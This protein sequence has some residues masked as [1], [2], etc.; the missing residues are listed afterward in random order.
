LPQLYGVMEIHNRKNVLI[1]APT[2]SGKTLTCFLSILNEL[3]DSSLKGILEDKVYA[4]YVSP[5]KALNQDIKVNLTQPLE[6]LEQLSEKKLGIRVGVRTGDTTAY[7]K[8]KMLKDPPHILITTPESLAIMLNS[9]KFL[10]H[11]SSVQWLIVDEIHSLAENK[12]GVHLSLS[13]ERLQKMCPGVTRVGLS[14]TIAPLEDIAH[15]LVGYNG[16]EER[17]CGIVDVQFLKEMDLKVVSPVRSLVDTD[18]LLKH[19]KM[20]DTM[21]E[22][23]Q[24][25]KTTLIFTNTRSA[26]ERVVHN[27]KEMY[28]QYYNGENIAAHHGSLG[29]TNRF[30]TEQNLRDGKLKVV[31]SSTSLELGIDIGYID[32]VICL[33]SPKSVARLLQRAGRAGHQLH[34]IVK[35]RVIVMDRDDLVECALLLKS[36]VEKKIDRVH[37]PKNALDVLAQHIYGIAINQTINIY[38]LFH[39]IKNTFCYHTLE[40]SD[41]F[42]TIKYL[43]GEYV[44][45]EERHVYAR[46]WHDPETGMI[47]RRG[48]MARIIYMTNIGTIPEETYVTVKIGEQIVGKIDEGFLERLRPGDVFVLGG[49]VYMF[50]FSRGMTAQVSTSVS[51]PPT[52]PSWFSEMLPL[53]FDLA[54]E[55]GRFRRLMEDRFAN[56]KSKEE[57]LQFIH[58]YLYVDENAA[59]SIYHYFYEQFHFSVI[60]SD[61]KIVIETYTDRGRTYVLFNTLFGRRVNDC[62]SRSLAYVIG[63]SQHRDVEIGITDNGFYLSAE[64]TFNAIRAFELLKTENFR[65]VLEQAIE[66]SEVLQRRFRHCA[67]RSLMILRDYMGRKKNVG[68]MHI[69]SKILFNAVKRISNDFPILKEARREVLEDLMDYGH[70]QEIIDAVVDGRIVLKEVQ[71]GM[72]GP[73][74]FGLIVSGYNDV[75]KIEDKHEFL[76]RMHQTVLANI[77]LKQGKKK[78]QEKKEEFSYAKLWQ[79]A[80]LKQQEEK[81]LQKEKMKM[82]VWNLKH[83][84]IYAK[85]ELVKLIEF[86]SMRQD[87]LNDCK[88]YL[89]EIEE[90]WPE[91]LKTFVL[92]KITAA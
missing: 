1:S 63:R 89:K 22:L 68:R 72:P 79:E 71:T 55:I 35:A 67:A 92:G 38:E 14:A 84:P 24:Q 59:E 25:H 47:G 20:Y 36:A 32:L 50:K 73:F 4:V 12:R 39:L 51:R 29:K 37:I 16:D 19:R 82:Q 69:G 64:K 10:M 7:E 44:S 76:R 49:N 65:T 26:T 61:K 28:P 58:E 70:A 13:L 21:H 27:L 5:L 75:I 15:Y 78:L 46:I 33:G 41:F 3:V 86:G 91:E 48:K 42:E 43:S 90:G 81:D 45:L 74:S 83:V 40:W 54:M 11:L 34:S 31:V 52:V 85:E 88:K 23:I 30:T 2:G 18:Y 17:D 80:Q 62:L 9:P 53:S 6:E 77:Q 8:Q 66:R 60:P 56:N 87:V 57:I